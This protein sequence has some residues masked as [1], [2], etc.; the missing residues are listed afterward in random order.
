M[1]F[2]VILSW[3]ACR[4]DG[5]YDACFVPAGYPQGINSP[6]IRWPEPD[7]REFMR[8]ANAPGQ[9]KLRNELIAQLVA[10]CSQHLPP[11]MVPR[12]ITLVDTLAHL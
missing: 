5:S 4:P 2:S 11:E 1:G 9:G 7:A 12:E 6:A 8:Q 3:A 10:H